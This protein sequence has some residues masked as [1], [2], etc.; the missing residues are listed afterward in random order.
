M[1]WN[2]ELP[3]V[4]K[5]QPRSHTES[6]LSEALLMSCQAAQ[7]RIL[8]E[9]QI[10]R[11][12]NVDN[13][14][15]G[16]G[17]EDLVRHELSNLLPDRYSVDAG[18][19]ND[20]RGRTAGDC[21]I[22]VRDRIW[23]PAIKL[24]ATPTSRR[25]HFPIESLYCAIELKQSF[26]LKQLDK[27]MKK[28]VT[29]ARLYRPF[30]SYGHITENQHLKYLDKE[31]HTLNPLHTAIMGTSLPEGVTFKTLAL[32]F[33]RINSYL[34][35]DEMIN[36]LCI[37]GHG[38]ASYEVKTGQTKYHD[39]TFM[40]DRSEDLYLSIETSR[41]EQVFYRFYVT[42]SGHLYRSVLNT[43]D[44]VATYG[45][46]NRQFEIREFVGALYNQYKD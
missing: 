1:K 20:S 40:W 30:N 25:F 42:L 10:E 36:T 22:V 38:V 46:V 44:I 19:V 14:D 26:G 5:W 33:G 6:T 45:E 27:A 7:C 35:R 9:A 28:L 12:F 3:D 34:N 15:S 11:S 23:A 18:V 37:L 17:V 43:R 39:P 21:D 2:E 8:R 29:I 32:R 31:G 41:P 13:F 4:T 16:P 24:G